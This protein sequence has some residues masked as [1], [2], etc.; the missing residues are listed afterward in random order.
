MY[1]IE[2]GFTKI[3]ILTADETFWPT[4]IQVAE[5]FSLKRRVSLQMYNGE[6]CLKKR[7]IIIR[8][9]D[10]NKKTDSVSLEIPNCG[11]QLTEAKNESMVGNNFE[12][13]VKKR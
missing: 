7:N 12:S 9:G 6:V 11:A 10:F 13:E 4:Q 1:Q 3:H 5:P 8:G 2:D